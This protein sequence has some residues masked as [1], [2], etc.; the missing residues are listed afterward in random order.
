M[1]LRGLARTS[2]A[3]L[4][5]NYVLTVYQMIFH[6]LKL[7]ERKKKL[8]VYLLGMEIELNLVPLFGELAYLLPAVDLELVLVSPAV[9]SIC[10]EA[11]SHKRSM[12]AR[13]DCVLDVTDAKG[14]G[15]VRVKLEPKHALFASIPN[16][17]K[18]DAVLC[19]N[20]GLGSYPEWQPTM[21]K[22]LR[23][24]IPFAFSDHTRLILSFTELIWFPS[25]IQNANRAFPQFPPVSVPQM[26]TSLNPFHSIVGRDLAYA[27]SPNIENGYIRARLSR[28]SVL[29]QH[30]DATKG[31]RIA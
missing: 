24:E 10:E 23:L 11:R 29:F 4:L 28:A 9:K 13:G 2:I 12:I 7:L 18:P 1:K 14:K 31:M 16:Y 22:I 17:P 25:F 19:L 15:R 27:Q 26:E 30:I 5:L 20:A 8:C 6:E 3:P 21:N